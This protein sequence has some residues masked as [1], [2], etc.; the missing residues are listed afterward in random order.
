MPNRDKPHDKLFKLALEDPKDAAIELRAVLP[1]ALA[2]HLDL[3]SLERQP[4]TFL[5]GAFKNS[6]TDLLFTTRYRGRE[7]LLYVLFE[8][9]S[10]PHRFT[11][12][13]LL[14][15][16]LNIWE[17]CLTQKPPPTHLPVI[18]P[19]I[20]YHCDRG[21][22]PPTSFHAL[23][24]PTLIADPALSRFTPN[25]EARLDDIGH[26]SDAEL[27]ARG[28]GPVAT[29]GFVF[30][31]DA[32]RRGRI[33]DVLLHWA[34]YFRA[35]RGISEGPRAT[36]QL[37]SY[38]FTV[39]PKLDIDDLRKRVH[40]AIPESEELVM[41]LAQKLRQEGRQ[42]GEMRG[43]DKGCRNVLSRQLE[44]KF[45]P[46]DADDLARIN[47]ADKSTLDRYIERVLTATS[48]HEVLRD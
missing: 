15:Y 48:V 28:L 18:I 1:P 46:L 36:N 4:D 16:M 30:L 35:L 39:A 5:D 24:D 26:L 25:F 20:V 11:V 45:G 2:T 47:A 23:F 22:S 19:V 41:T 33:L 37:F 21:R 7:A 8:H 12:L 14:R 3:D 40:Q 42:E 34:D 43:I 44:L 6:S 32:R 31:R 38:L 29:L 13:Q 10:R 27:R 9:K 17:K